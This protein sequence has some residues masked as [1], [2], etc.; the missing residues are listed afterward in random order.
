MESLP[1]IPISPKWQKQVKI[2][3]VKFDFQLV[4]FGSLFDDSVKISAS[5]HEI[6]TPDRG[7]LRG[8]PRKVLRE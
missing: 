4:Y 5:L 1:V 6:E 3:L 7:T 8:N 2:L